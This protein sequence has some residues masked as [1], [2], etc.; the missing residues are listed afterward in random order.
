MNDF[1]KL[2]NFSISIS[3]FILMLIGLLFSLLTRIIDTRKKHFFASI[4]SF[5]LLYVTSNLINQ[6]SDNYILSWISL[7]FESFFS[8]ILLLLLT[9]YI[10]SISG[11]DYKKSPVF[12]AVFSLWFIYFIML[13]LTWFTRWI[14][15]FTPDNVYHRGPFYPLLL[16][17]PV[18]ILLLN[19]VTLVHLRSS[20]TSKQFTAL[21]IYILVPMAAMILQMFFYGIYFIVLGT[22]LAGMAMYIFIVVD[23]IELFTRQQE[24]NTRQE[25]RIMVL[26]MRPHF[27]FNTMTSIYYL[28]EQ[29]PK[30]AQKI[31]MDFTNYL[32]GNFSAIV[33]EKMIPFEKEL[34]HTKAYLAVEE[35]RFDERVFVHF[36]IDSTD[37]RIPPLTL[38]PIVE[39]AIKHGINSDLD[40]LTI[41]IKTHETEN[42]NEIIVKD[43][44]PGFTIPDDNEP[45]IALENIRKRLQ[46]MCRGK[47][48]VTNSKTTGTIVRIFLPKADD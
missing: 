21:L 1:T 12:H 31:I 33:S 35:E 47:L 44:G 48:D 36:D 46:I 22:A 14:Y 34:E 39:N 9:V 7:F 11:M 32:R 5:Q 13:H 6:I 29:D 17:P 41:N 18:L 40:V 4:F 23:Q 30:K 38:Q 37:F 28:V 26:E 42:G 27:I 45:H 25:A 15:Y 20:I 10:L 8:S 2:T 24:E 16:I 43:S 19:L 3:A